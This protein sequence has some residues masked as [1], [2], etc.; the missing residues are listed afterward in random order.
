MQLTV[1]ALPVLLSHATHLPA[2]D[3]AYTLQ[4][5]QAQQAPAPALAA[6]QA[7]LGRLVAAGVQQLVGHLLSVPSWLVSREGWQLSLTHSGSQPITMMPGQL[8][9]SSVQCINSWPA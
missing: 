3:L 5:L 4:Q 2:Q 6:V 7:V 9:V 1:A 8:Q